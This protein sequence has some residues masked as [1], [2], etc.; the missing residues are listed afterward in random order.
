MI[1]DFE[2]QVCDAQINFVLGTELEEQ[3]YDYYGD[4]FYPFAQ[5][6]TNRQVNVFP[7]SAE[8]PK[9]GK[10]TAKEKIVYDNTIRL[11]GEALAPRR[12]LFTANNTPF[13]L[14]KSDT[15]E[16]RS[17]GFCFMAYSMILRN[18]DSIPVVY[19]LIV[20]LQRF[21][22]AVE[23]K[24]E[25]SKIALQDLNSYCKKLMKDWKFSGNTLPPELITS[26]PYDEYVP[27]KPIRPYDHQIAVNK[28]LYDPVLARSGFIAV[29][30]TATNSGKT[31][32]AVGL[33]KRVDRL[34]SVLPKMQFLF[35]CVVD[36]V[37]KKV[38]NLFQASGISYGV[39]LPRRCV[40]NGC[41]VLGKCDKHHRDQGEEDF[42]IQDPNAKEILVNTE[43]NRN[44]LLDEGYVIRDS[45]DKVDEKRRKVAIIDGDTIIR[46][47]G[48]QFNTNPNF[49]AIVCKPEIAYYFLQR[50]NVGNSTV[51]FLDEFTLNA[52]NMDSKELRDHMNVISVAPKWTYLSN[53]NFVGDDRI[54]AFLDIHND[55]FPSSTIVHIASN[56]V[57]SCSNLWTF[58]GKACL[59]HMDAGDSDS[60][61]TKVRLIYENQFKGRMYNPQAIREMYDMATRL[62]KWN[63]DDED[64]GVDEKATREALAKLPDI[65]TILSDVEQLYPD[66]IRK[67]AMK[68]LDAVVHLDEDE[69][70]EIFSKV[71]KPKIKPVDI[72]ELDY[73][74]FPGMNLVGHTDPEA[75]TM[76]MF[77]GHLESIKV[78]IG[79][80]KK[81]ISS[82]EMAMDKWQSAYDDLDKRY[83]KERDLADAREAS[84]ETMPKIAFPDD[85]QIG[86][87]AFLRGRTREKVRIPLDIKSINIELMKN[88]DK[89][90]LLYAGVGIYSSREK[91]RAYLDT[92]LDLASTGRL[93][94]LVTD[95]S[96]GMDYPFSCVFISKE[97][98]DQRSMN[99][100]YQ[101]ICRGGR[102]RLSNS[103]QIYMDE[104]CMDRITSVKDETSEIEL[105]NMIKVLKEIRA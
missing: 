79:S 92:V 26:A 28:L 87:P 20:S 98:S 2:K 56:V 40:V 102:G 95:I 22:H 89:I 27:K 71:P 63:F 58:S 84:L 30:S 21:I 16:L 37:R 46:N 10:M 94:F 93:E 78:R 9:P 86:T 101:F 81:M 29:Y 45:K 44:M 41:R 50:E 5:D 1:T 32:T 54:R 69:V 33:A 8:K 52:T 105:R 83:K 12:N 61:K 72:L 67:I 18:E 7:K 85:L 31:F 24:P 17:I 53:A 91:D 23:T 11:I 104:T 88:E 6:L 13:A 68:I 70:S 96:Y 99:D 82:Y 25:F 34:R 64:D 73:Y 48:S 3:V 43:A 75:Y 80:L 103:A 51:L 15:L 38:E 39:A 60:F 55:R 100:I 42:Y 62:V 76:K 19:G 65:D 66:N 57:F 90:L 49:T 14:L 4:A 97:Y 74:N 36:S 59:P 47:P 35:S 77:S